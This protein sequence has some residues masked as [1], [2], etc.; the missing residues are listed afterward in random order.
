MQL[1]NLLSRKTYYVRAYAKTAD[2]I[3]YGNQISF[4]TLKGDGPLIPNV[5]YVSPNGDDTTADGSEADP[6]FL[7]Q[8]AIDLVEPGDVIIMEGGTYNYT[9]R[10]NIGTAGGPGDEMIQLRAEEGKRALL[11]FSA[12]PVDGALQGIRLTGSYWHIYGLDIK[13]AGDNGM[14]IE[15]NKPTGG[16]FGDIEA[17]TDQAHDNVIE[18][19]SFFENRDTGL[20]IGRAHV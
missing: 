15:R 6:F 14:L 9:E 1:T 3:F 10:I 8:K 16:K 12:M 20:Q 7:V 17:L 18:F 11:D 4:K 5:Y 13:G 2:D 19:C